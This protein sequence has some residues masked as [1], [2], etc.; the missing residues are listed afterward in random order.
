MRIPRVRFSVRR[1]LIGVAV[2]AVVVGG[3]LQAWVWPRVARARVR[4]AVFYGGMA[5]YNR[6]M[7]DRL[8]SQIDDAT[9]TIRVRI[10]FGAGDSEAELR[11]FRQGIPVWTAAI[12]RH[13]DRADW[14]EGLA[15]TYRRAALK[16]WQSLDPDPPGPEAPTGDPAVEAAFATGP[17]ARMPQDGTP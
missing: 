16:P 9:E 4:Q 12:P 2:V 3:L 15:R 11:R 6:F 7:A 5:R 14:A 10:K 1:L 17:M 8:A 13:R